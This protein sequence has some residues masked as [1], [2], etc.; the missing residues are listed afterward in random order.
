M[1]LFIPSIGTSLVL[2]QDWTFNLHY[3]YRN[4]KLWE[5]LLGKDAFANHWRA[6]PGPKPK[7]VVI[8]LPA[9]TELVVSRI[10]I[11]NGQGDFDSV[12]FSAKDLVDLDGKKVKS[13]RFW[14]KL[15]DVNKIICEVKN[16]K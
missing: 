13:A 11:R 5:V 2:K 16:G 1:N 14:A 10:Y 7:P 6:N 9:E 3:E 15:N 12:T 8:T 4:R